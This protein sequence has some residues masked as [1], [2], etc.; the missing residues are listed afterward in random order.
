MDS[1][2][3]GVYGLTVGNRKAICCTGSDSTRI[4]A[5][6]QDRFFGL[7]LHLHEGRFRVWFPC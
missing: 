3:L 4:L 6:S 1:L 5:G 2:L 7:Q